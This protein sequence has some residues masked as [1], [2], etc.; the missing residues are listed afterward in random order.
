MCNFHNLRNKFKG[1]SLKLWVKLEYLFM[2][3]L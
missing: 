3:F 1:K 2:M